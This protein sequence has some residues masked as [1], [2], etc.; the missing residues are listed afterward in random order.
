VASSNQRDMMQS[1]GQQFTSTSQ[2]RGHSIAQLRR[3]VQRGTYHVSSEQIAERMLRDALLEC[4][5]RVRLQ[6]LGP[7]Q[8]DGA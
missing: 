7:T 5:M 1:I 2:T 3:A 4:L 6:R 8:D